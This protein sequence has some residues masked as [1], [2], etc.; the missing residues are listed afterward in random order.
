MT[1]N[2][3]QSLNRHLNEGNIVDILIIG[4]GAIGLGIAYSILQK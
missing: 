1:N 4:G 3:L 2:R